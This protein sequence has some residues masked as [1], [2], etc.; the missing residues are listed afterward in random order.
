PTAGIGLYNNLYHLYWGLPAYGAQLFDEGGLAVVDKT[1]DAAAYLAWL[2]AVGETTGSYVD[3]DYGMLLDRFKK[4][5][6][7][8]FV[9]GPWA[10]DELRGALGENLAVAQ[11]PAGP[12]GSAQPWLT[13]DGVFV[14]PTVSPEQQALA[15]DF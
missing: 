7:A 12:A 3:P 14:N 10:I 1:G 8:Y 6:F 4:G 2:R 9:D 15:L 13:A 11:L 5:E